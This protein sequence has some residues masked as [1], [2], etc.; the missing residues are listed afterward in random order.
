MKKDLE[1]LQLKAEFQQ[2]A[3]LLGNYLNDNNTGKIQIKVYKKKFLHAKCYI[4][5][6]DAE[7]AVGIIGSSNFTKQG[8]FGNLE[9]NQ[10]EDNNATVN[11]LR[12]NISQHPS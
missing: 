7:N 5:G 10:F 11:F 9:L 4:F 2:V 3:E 12:K 1:D 6:T 8:L